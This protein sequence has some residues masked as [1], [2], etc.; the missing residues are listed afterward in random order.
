MLTKS[1]LSPDF[2]VYNFGVFSQKIKFLISH[3]L[4]L[5]N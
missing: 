3:G 4:D 1:I 2:H 5:K